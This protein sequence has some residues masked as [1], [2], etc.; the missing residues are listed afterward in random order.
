[1]FIFRHIH[2]IVLTAFVVW[3]QIN[4]FDLSF[5][6][7]LC[8]RDNGGD[9][10][11]LD[12]SEE[13]H[14]LI[15]NALNASASEG[16]ECNHRMKVVLPHDMGLSLQSNLT[17]VDT[18]RFLKVGEMYYEY[19]P[20]PCVELSFYND[21][22]K[23]SFGSQATY[24]RCANPHAAAA[25]GACCKDHPLKMDR[26]FPTC[27]YTGERI[28]FDHL[29]ERCEAQ[30]RKVPC[31]FDKISQNGCGSCCNVQHL[32]WTPQECSILAKVN[33]GGQVSI[34]HRPNEAFDVDDKYS[35]DAKNFFSVSWE[36][37]THPSP[38]NG[39]GDGVC[40]ITGDGSCLCETREVSQPV[41]SDFNAIVQMNLSD[42]RSLFHIGSF[43]PASH[44]AGTFLG[45]KAIATKDGRE[46][47]IWSS[48]ERP[49]SI[50]D[51]VVALPG[52]AG[53]KHYR[54]R[55]S[56]VQI[57]D[58]VGHSK[59]SFR[60]PPS[61]G[62]DIHD[63]AHET[64]ALLDHLF[65]H[66]NTAPFI[67]HRLIQRLGSSNPSPGYIERVATAFTTGS[68]TFDG[69]Q[70]GSKQYGCLKATVAAIF[71][72]RELRSEVLDAD[73]SAGSLREPLLRL[74]HF[75]RSM[76]FKPKTSNAGKLVL[77]DLEEEIGEMP[78]GHPSVFSFFLPDYKSPGPIASAGLVSPEATL[79]T[80]PYVTGLVKG[81]ISL[82]KY[83]MVKC[84]GGFGHGPKSCRSKLLAEGSYEGSEGQLHYSPRI[85]DLQSL[86]EELNLL[87]AGGRLGQNDQKMISDA[88][89]REQ[90]KA[91]R[92]DSAYLVRLAQQLIV[93]T[94]AFHTSALVGQELDMS[95]HD[96]A[97][98]STETKSTG[99]LRS[100][101]Q[102]EGNSDVRRV[103]NQDPL[104]SNLDTGNRGYKAII[105]L[106]L[107]GGN[108][109]YNMFVPLSDCQDRNLYDEYVKVRGKIALDKDELLPIDVGTGQPCSTFGIHSSFPLLAKM[110]NES[111]ASIV[112]NSGLLFEPSNAGNFS[113]I[114][115]ST[116]L[117]AHDTQRRDT[118][119]AN[120]Q[121]DAFS[122][123]M[124]GR[125]VDVLT[126]YGFSTSSV[127][128]DNNADVLNPAPFSKSNGVEFINA[129][130]P[131]KFYE[132][133]SSSS[134]ENLVLQLNTGK[135]SLGSGMYGQSFSDMLTKAQ[136]STDYF[137]DVLNRYE[138]A[139]VEGKNNDIEEE[140]VPST[141]LGAKLDV[142]KKLIWAR[143]ERKVERDVFFVTLSGFDHHKELL[144]RQK[145]K[146][147]EINSALK[148]FITSMKVSGVWDNI[149]VASA[150][151]FG[152]TLTANSNAGSD[153]SWASHHFIAG[154]SVK[155][156]Q[157]FGHYPQTLELDGD[158][159]LDRGRV[160]PTM[161]NEAYW[162]GILEWFGVQDSELD[163][164]L[165]N[166]KSTAKLFS[167]R[168]MFDNHNGVE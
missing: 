133:P 28:T 73:P 51:A 102:R 168:D 134:L 127:A 104:D 145:E 166:R 36:Q 14:A 126:N 70:F 91:R 156:G 24:S 23:V 49:G 52:P 59:Y 82:I 16:D 5:L 50:Q 135:S 29:I 136:K 9:H 58:A 6:F 47:L 144:P 20:A 148:G 25:G 55:E 68:A 164:V 90:D 97:L 56:S 113:A 76:E 89:A 64:E 60:N 96:R 162:N 109:G 85:D 110:F 21:G 105:Y 120:P 79:L 129:R 107:I 32:L 8:R 46:V 83:G 128:L 4:S 7:S 18:V 152:R 124:L 44:D 12:P 111:E 92:K 38:N 115:Q 77:L 71:L 17:K 160:I 15:C 161:A 108:D 131:T 167:E 123:G 40:T 61:F 101:H 42:L 57:I 147:D 48:A 69:I 26:A 67:S 3:P 39:C 112:A 74:V 106:L 33:D 100:Y 163:R 13:L 95:P 27:E 116:R 154:G 43:D 150:S 45:P 98:M 143:N 118:M 34:V 65:F 142:V 132:N 35:P 41:L 125:A 121:G 86:V 80:Q 117:F 54:N 87:L 146:L 10:L 53:T 63:A 66:S 103:Q 138:S 2:T 155:G 78:Y 37:G 31:D 114:H 11:D 88:L 1:M 93:T 141:S 151:D 139:P 22:K 153:H 99:F 122:T 119:M 130:K 19:Q 158:I 157:V 137:Y 62:E 84:E 165:P 149:V 30:D 94:P 75:M 140:P 159:I 81:L 72:D